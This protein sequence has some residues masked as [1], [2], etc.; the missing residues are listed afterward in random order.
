[1]DPVDVELRGFALRKAVW[2]ND[3]LLVANFLVED[4]EHRVYHLYDHHLPEV[5]VQAFVYVAWP[6][7]GMPLYEL[8]KWQSAPTVMKM[9]AA[10]DPTQALEEFLEVYDSAVA[11]AATQAREGL[12]GLFTE[13]P[14][15]G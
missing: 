15:A 4:V 9:W 10:P 12:I 11:Y 5:S 3:G 14:T 6:L 7:G 1:M 8:R 13:P 2:E